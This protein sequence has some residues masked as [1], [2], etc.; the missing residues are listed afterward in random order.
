MTTT[1][2]TH[3]DQRQSTALAEASNPQTAPQDLAMILM[4][5]NQRVKLAVA[6]NPATSSDLL[7]NLRLSKNPQVRQAAFAR[8]NRG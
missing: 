2:T 4:H 1:A 3:P 5:A 8:R 6:Q 7:L